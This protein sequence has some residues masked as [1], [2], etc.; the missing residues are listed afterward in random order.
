MYLSKGKFL[1]KSLANL[2]YSVFTVVIV[3][4]SAGLL[5]LWICCLLSFKLLVLFMLGTILFL[6]AFFWF[7]KHLHACLLAYELACDK[8]V[9][10][11]QVFS[12]FS[13]QFY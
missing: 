1:S 3:C 4:L 12:L 9:W 7:G 8:L 6:Y 5:L 10:Y 11:V 2:I 13:E